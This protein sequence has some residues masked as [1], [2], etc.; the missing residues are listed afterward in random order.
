MAT[1]STTGT[2]AISS[3]TGRRSGLP[4]GF[5]SWKRIV[6][7]GGSS[8]G[9]RLNS[10]PAPSSAGCSAASGGSYGTRSSS[11]LPTA[12]CSPGRQYAAPSSGCPS[13]RTSVPS[14]GATWPPPRPMI[15]RSA[16]GGIAG[17]RS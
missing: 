2:T 12:T 15:T 16:S 14:Y 11:V 4:G 8:R 7:P 9:G 1:P 6:P 17:R 5:G 13:S 3:G 10:R